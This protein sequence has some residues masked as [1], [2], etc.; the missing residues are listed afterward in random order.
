MI[1]LGI[2]ESIPRA[3]DLLVVSAVLGQTS[4]MKKLHNGWSRDL[5]NTNVDFFHAK[6]HWNRR[7][8]PYHGLSMTKRRVLLANLVGHLRRFSQAGITVSIKPD[9]YTGMTDN[10][11]R[12]N[13]GAPY[14]F[15][16]QIL[17]LLVYIDLRIRNRTHEEVNILIEEGHK[18][19]GQV[20]EII[21]KMKGS[22]EAF[23]R[24][25][26]YGFGPKKGNP[27]LQ[28]ADML[29]YGA[30]Q[31][32]AT[33][34]SRIYRQL[35]SRVKPRQ[36]QRLHITAALISAVK[37][38]IAAGSEKKRQER[39]QQWLEGGMKSEQ[40]KRIDSPEAFERF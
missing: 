17:V 16:I 25:N 9:E 30:A 33:Q 8:A 2:D 15:A 39:L 12:S 34:D 23:I 32:I 37:T 22:A 21:P 26:S 28:A 35:A 24:L 31:H 6:D 19:L 14:A 1:D 10:A 29:A 40:P 4:L 11:F 36:F 20:S 18:N 3:G 38:N 5:A 7:Y 27:I 13:W